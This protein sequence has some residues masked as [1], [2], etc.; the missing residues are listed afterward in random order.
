M[1]TSLLFVSVGLALLVASLIA[2]PVHANLTTMPPLSAA[3][4]A[5]KAEVGQQLFAAKGCVG[6]HRHA[7]F[8]NQT[9]YFAPDGPPDLTHHPLAPAYLRLWLRDPKAVKPQTEMPNLNLDDAEI[10]ALTAFLSADV[11]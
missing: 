6:C 4:V 7:A 11:R 5:A 1:K 3:S 9:L 2:W 8:R 10:E